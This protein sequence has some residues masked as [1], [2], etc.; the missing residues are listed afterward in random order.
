[1][2][3]R[4]FAIAVTFIGSMMLMIDSSIVGVVLPTIAKELNIASSS[5]VIMVTVYQLILAMT[6][7]SMA[8]LGDRIGFR[9]LYQAGFSLHVVAAVASLFVSTLPAL[10]AVRA[11]QAL[12]AAAAMSMNVA[13]LREM[14]PARRLG[15]GLGLNTIAN[16]T[17]TSLGPVLGGFLLSIGNW[18]WAFV[19]IVP[20]SLL[21]LSMSRTLPEPN[22][23]EHA[24]D[25]I[26]AGLC[27]LTFGLL[28]FG[29]ESVI[30]GGHLLLSLLL[31]VAGALTGWFF[32]RHELGETD[33]VLPLD[34]L[35]MPPIAFSTIACFCAT[36]ASIMLILFM[37]FRLQNGFGFSAGEL[38]GLISLYAVGSLLTAPAAGLLSDRVPVALLSIIAMIIASLALLCVAFLPVHPSHFDIGWRM[39]FCG[40]GFGIFSSPNARLMVASAPANR[41]AS[42][43][44]IF[45]TTRMLSQAVGATLVA[46]LLAMG[47]GNGA[48][49]ALI[50]MG[51]AAVAGAISVLSLLY[52]RRQRQTVA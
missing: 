7:M 24:F 18:H 13:L 41:T 43:G 35:A 52:S 39:C 22:P 1:M 37:P 15:A 16:A 14:Y 8:A 12:G 17:G 42:A 10:V 33:P 23:R 9:R 36:I 28:T 34:L 45:T 2:P 29:L 5:T 49:P 21:V 27:A 19:A 51:F 44:S 31:L 11:L 50:A 48:K 30:H 20:F 26:G 4:I 47:L 32:V 25:V 6:V 38:G 46:A 40:I 3:R